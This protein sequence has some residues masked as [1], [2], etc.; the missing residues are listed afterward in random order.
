MLQKESDLVEAEVSKISALQLYRTSASDL[1]RAQ[2]TIL[3]THNIV[4]GS[5]SPL[6]NGMEPEAFGVGDLLEPVLP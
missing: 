3:R 1:D 4:V 5:V 6:R 2:G